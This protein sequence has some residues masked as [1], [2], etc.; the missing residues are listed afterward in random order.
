MSEEN[1]NEINESTVEETVETVETTEE[2]KTSSLK[3]DLKAAK[4]ALR[5]VFITDEIEEEFQHVNDPVNHPDHYNQGSMETIEEM[6]LMFGG[7]NVITFCFMNAW[8]YRA[9]AP[10]NDPVQD[11]AKADWYMKVAKQLMDDRDSKEYY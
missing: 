9:R 2:T 4:E 1:L 5:N 6:L 3:E 11:L 10:Y 7:E 8:K